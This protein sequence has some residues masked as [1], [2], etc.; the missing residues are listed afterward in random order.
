MTLIG[1]LYDSGCVFSIDTSGSN[2]KDLL[3]FDGTNGV[4]PYASLIRSG[5]K[6]LGM[7]AMGSAFYH[8]NIFSIDTNGKWIQGLI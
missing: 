5:S 8:G 1:G 2:Y 7:T 4:A 6:L 3:D